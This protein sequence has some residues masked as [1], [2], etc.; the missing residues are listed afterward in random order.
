MSTV[1]LTAAPVFAAPS[2]VEHTPGTQTFGEP[3]DVT[4]REPFVPREDDTVDIFF[5][6]SF[7]F[8]Y[9]R[10]C[11][12]YTTDGSDP[13]GT[14]GTPSGSTQVLGNFN[15]LAT[16]VRNENTVEGVRDWWTTTLPI[17][18]RQFGQTSRYKITAWD[19]GGGG[20]FSANGFNSYDYVNKLAWPGAGAG[21]PN[22]SL[23]Y[24]PVSFWKEEAVVGNQYINVIIDQNGTV[25]DIYYP[26]AGAV[27]GVGTKNEGYADGRDTFPAFTSGRGQMHTNQLMAGIRIDGTT[28]WMSNQNGLGYDSVM[29][30]YHPT[31]NT[32]TTSARLHANGNN[33]QV[34]QE[35]FSPLGVTFPNINGG[36]PNR[37]I[38]LKRFVLTNNGPVSKTVNFYFY[39]DFAINGGDGSDAM[40]QDT[41]AS[42]GAMYAY[43]NVG[44]SANS[45]GEYNPTFDPDYPKDNSIFFGSA[46]KLCSSVGGASGTPATDSWRDTSADNGQGWIGLQL[47]LAPG[48]AQEI[49][50]AVIGGYQTGLHSDT[51]DN[52]IRPALDWFFANSAA[53]LKTATDTYWTNWLNEGVTVDLPDDDY[54]ELFRRGLLATALHIDGPTGAMIA[55]FHN[56]AYPF[57]WPR[58]AVYGAVCM[59]RTG[60]EAE[61]AGVYNWMRDTCYRDNEPWGKGFWKQ[62]YTTNGYTVW[63][64][65]Q[66]D[67]TAVFP[68]GLYYH[69]LVTGDTTFLTSH[70]ATMKEAA[71]TIHSNPS[72]PALLPF[73]NYNATEQLMWSNNVWEDQYNFFAYSN[74]NV[75]A[76]LRDA[77]AIANALGNNADEADFAG[78]QATIKAGLDDWLD[79]NSEITDISQLGI[80]YPFQVYHPQDTRAVRY[81][82]RINGVQS[83]SSGNSHPLVNFTNDYGWLDL[84]NRYWGDNY[85][86][87]SDDPVNTP[88]GAGPWFLS[89]AWYGLYYAERADYTANKTDID[90]HKYRMDLLID[91]LGPAGFGAE[92][93][94]PYCNPCTCPDCGSLLYPNQPD[95]VLQT[96]WPNA[97]ESMSTF[98]DA[99]MAFLDFVPDAPDGAFRI[100]PKL[101]TG[102]STMQF[103]NLHVG[104]S[105]LN[106]LSTESPG[107]NTCAITNVSG[108]AMTYH[109]YVR[110]PGGSNVFAVTQDCSAHAWNS[111][112]TIGKVQIDG[113]LNASAAST[114]TLRV[115]YGLR[116]DFDHDSA[117]DLDD[118]P[119]LVN[120]LLGLDTDCVKFPIADCNGDGENDGL[121]IAPFTD[122]LVP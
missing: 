75:V 107:I 11:V 117:V 114:T 85:W 77:A 34:D 9:D 43:D 101:P 95:F 1:F 51:G 49:D 84:I 25:Y 59:A 58:D 80:V 12:Y 47:T 72:N 6:V 108:G 69:Y 62:K 7:Q 10:V 36:G 22:P 74:A 98:V 104:A 64:S 17:G 112:P 67:E 18:A 53:T 27:Y 65:P 93:I 32:V 121:D 79:D 54:D 76:G 24:P 70:Y 55:G 38:Y 48:V 89:T 120:I 81:I 13:M 19:S 103:N 33:I 110:V 68:W 115:Y 92:Q 46:L 105:R 102:W 26:G 30:A 87:R 44:G 60:H 96:A 94:S 83:D 5:R 16:F 91:R 86:G 50:L 97:W 71:T 113:T 31:S 61:S 56:G 39:G 21:S 111:E 66:I 106:V 2:A 109:V 20:E 40:Y 37:G 119:V 35:D 88:W 8:A 118:I 3:A 42:H 41:G 45:R 73:L 99:I 82:D 29:Q 116:G 14:F 57:C 23:G 28:Y 122:A 78:W 100:A 63:S 4:Q 90:N 52:Q 15:G